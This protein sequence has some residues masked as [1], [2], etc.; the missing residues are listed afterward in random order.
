MIYRL[1]TFADSA[2]TGLLAALPDNYQ[3]ATLA[4]GADSVITGPGVLVVAAASEL[5]AAIA[6]RHR[7]VAVEIVTVSDAE[8]PPA[9][10][11]PIYA[12]LTPT[13]PIPVI[14]QA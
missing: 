10:V 6:L 14:A 4:A 7:H 13:L 2:A 3:C 5:D 9:P 12:T 8:A 1:F 11:E